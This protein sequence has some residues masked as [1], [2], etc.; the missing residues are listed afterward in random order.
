MS[1]NVDS[2]IIRAFYNLKP[3]LL[4]LLL[5][6]VFMTKGEEL[7]HKIAADL[8]DAQEGRMFGALCI[9]APN[10]KASVMFWKEFLV[11][12]LDGDAQAEALKLKGAQVFSP[13]E[14]RP[15]GGWI[16]LSDEHIKKWQRYATIAHEFVKKIEAAPKKVT[17]KVAAPKKAAKKVVAPKKSK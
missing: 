14:G 1:Q 12:K 7:Y 16:Q 11:V 6:I 4:S 3:D 8:A 9:K 15:M 13:M 5:T 2:K 10:G 17:K